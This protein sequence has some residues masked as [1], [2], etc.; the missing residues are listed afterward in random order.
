MKVSGIELLYGKILTINI[1][2]NEW[3]IPVRILILSWELDMIIILTLIFS[4][5]Y[6]SE[7]KLYCIYVAIGQKRSTVAQLVK[8]LTDA[9]KDKLRLPF[10]RMND[11]LS[12]LH[13]STGKGT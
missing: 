13:I 11:T 12:S 5:L 4:S 1:Q 6:F 8:R 7:K 10:A 2:W 9:G 3:K